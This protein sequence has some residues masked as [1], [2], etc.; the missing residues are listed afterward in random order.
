MCLKKKKNLFTIEFNARN[1]ET[2]LEHKYKKKVI[3]QQMRFFQ[4]TPPP[5]NLFAGKNL[6][7]FAAGVYGCGVKLIIFLKLYFFF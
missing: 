4:V 2:R 5:S 1:D 7:G 3:N 6:Q